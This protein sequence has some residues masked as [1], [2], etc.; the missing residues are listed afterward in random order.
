MRTHSNRRLVA[1]LSVCILVVA[2]SCTG[3]DD[4]VAGAGS[5]N[6]A[7]ASSTAGA[8]T[9][10]T[11]VR[12][13]ELSMLTY[14]VAGLPQGLSGSNPQEYMP[15]IGPK[16]ND[17]DLVV[18][19]EDFATPD[20]NP[21]PLGF[22]HEVLVRTTGHEYKSAPMVPPVG[23]DPDRPSA[24]AGDGLNMFSDFE[25]GPVYR[26]AWEKCFG[27]ADTSDGGAGDCLALKG[28]SVATVT[29]ADGVVID[30]YDVHGE[31]GGTPMDAEASR[32][33]YQELA[34]YILESS[35]GN[36]IILGG[37]TNLS[38]DRSEGDAEVW[39]AFLEATGL[40]DIC[41]A[42]TCATQPGS[43]DKFAYRSSAEITLEPL[44]RVVETEK[45]LAPG[46][47]DL[48][49]GQLS[50]HE[51]ISSRWRWTAG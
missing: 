15:L 46:T 34:E 38:T 8:S 29:L 21:L 13:G 19:Q 37:D 41:R 36:A 20:P 48:N 26:Q 44:E 39:D 9:T 14:N 1:G 42:I 31:A 28:F 33:D 50:D 4:D 16:L 10:T 3:D 43:I 47:P 17:Y 22:F 18:T 7:G 6:S 11:P 35:E 12:S 24:I 45:F 32:S 51:A 5:S 2:A 27:G 49:D 30:V 25:I 23:S 40:E